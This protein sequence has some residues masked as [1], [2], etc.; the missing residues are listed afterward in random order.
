MVA[1]LRRVGIDARLLEETP[2]CIQKSLR[3]NSGQCIPLNI[4]TQ[5]FIDYVE[6][7]QLDP[8]KTVLWMVSSTISC[9]LGLF[10]HHIKTLLDAYGRG[11]E[12]VG[13]YT[14]SLSFTD[15]SLKLPLNT[16]LA[17]MVGGLVRRVGCK[18]RPYERVRGAT[19]R[20]IKEGMDVLVEAF[21]GNLSKDRKWRFSATSMPATMRL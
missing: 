17:Y 9:N 12:K 8:A 6:S 3:Y 19:D 2:T 7:H 21:S 14:G 20:V 15:I 11:M 16:Y 4:I 1:G 13:I 10:P 18:I 5:E